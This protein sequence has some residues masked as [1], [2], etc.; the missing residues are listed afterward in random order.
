MWGMKLDAEQIKLL[1]IIHKEIKVLD[2]LRAGNNTPPLINKT[3]KYPAPL[4]FYDS[5]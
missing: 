4:P 3:I 1:G 5:G 2:A